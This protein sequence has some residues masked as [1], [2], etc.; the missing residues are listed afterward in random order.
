MRVTLMWCSTPWRI[1]RL[2]L[3]A[4]W[5]AACLWLALPAAATPANPTHVQL[6]GSRLQGEA[7]LRYWGL[8]VYHAKL[9]TLPSFRPSEATEQ[10]LVLELEYLLNLKGS[11]I[12]DT[13]IQEM[14]R[15]GRFTD[16]Q[17]Q[18][19]LGEM[20]R[21]FPDVKPGDRLSGLLLPGQ[22]VRFWHNSRPLGEVSDAEFARLFVGIWLAPTTSEPQM[23]LSLLGSADVGDR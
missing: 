11:A 16:A 9:W 3:A 17:A 15:A 13:S 8:K 7:T 20:Q 5:L 10:P 1:E 19:W 2:S 4:C 22:G 6:N 21:L 23:R 18:R 14:R 12:A